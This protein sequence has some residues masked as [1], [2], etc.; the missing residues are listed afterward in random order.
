[1][2][3]VDSR[4]RVPPRRRR[5]Q[6]QSVDLADALAH[7]RWVAAGSHDYRSMTL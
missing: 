4:P 3:N 5:R 7:A 6:R 1:M 2:D